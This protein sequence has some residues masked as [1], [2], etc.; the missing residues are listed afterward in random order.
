LLVQCGVGRYRCSS[1]WLQRWMLRQLSLVVRLLLH[2]QLR[3]MERGH[4]LLVLE[5]SHDAWQLMVLPR[6]VVHVDIVVEGIVSV[7]TG[8]AAAVLRVCAGMRREAVFTSGGP[9]IPPAYAGG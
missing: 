7:Q 8:V 5:L 1:E 6:R 9:G 3:L 2:R 4:R